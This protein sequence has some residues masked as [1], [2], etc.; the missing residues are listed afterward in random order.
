MKLTSEDI[1]WEYGCNCA[2]VRKADNVIEVQHEKVIELMLAKFTQVGLYA[3]ASIFH[4]SVERNK[5]REKQLKIIKAVCHF[6]ADWPIPDFTDNYDIRHNKE[7]CKNNLYVC[8]KAEFNQCISELTGDK[9]ALTD[10][11]ALKDAVTQE[12]AEIDFQIAGGS[13]ISKLVV[14]GDEWRNGDKCVWKNGSGN[15]VFVGLLPFDNTI[16]VVSQGSFTFHMNIE[17][18]SRPETAEQK[19]AKILH[20]KVCGIMQSKGYEAVD[21]DKSGLVYTAIE[22]MLKDGYTK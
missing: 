2:I 8:S 12:E 4:Y 18:M 21:C 16:A 14:K 1:N 10:N 6:R 15:G 19:A 9:Q 22:M 11:L 3:Y 20:E 13:V 5:A 17:E 7:I